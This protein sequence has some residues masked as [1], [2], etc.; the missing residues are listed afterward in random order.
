MRNILLLGYKNC[1]LFY[2]LNRR[3]NLTHTEEKLTL[4]QI[5]E[6]DPDLIVSFGY[7]H[8]VS[9]PIIEKYRN[10]I[11]NLHISYLPWN[12][13]A[14]PNLWSFVEKTP[15]GVT[16]HLMDEGIDTG[17]ILFQ[18]TVF[19]K[20]SYTLKQ[21]HSILVKEIQSL[22]IKKWKIIETLKFSGVKQDLSKGSYH[23]KKQTEKYMQK[24]GVTSWDIEVKKLIV[25]SD[26]DIINDIQEIRARN[27]EHWM[28]L[29]KLAFRT[30]PVESRAIFKK[31]KFCDEKVN[32]LLKELSEND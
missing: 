16:I 32:Q 15:K 18:K 10:K 20:N 27:N 9:K 4:Q 8:I 28:D 7:R 11:I 12:R 21:T 17:D 30:T 26:E 22:F 5:D 31:I 3:S 1:D 24:I 13:G 25:R 14:S 23:T 29:V 6:I 2:F 19:L